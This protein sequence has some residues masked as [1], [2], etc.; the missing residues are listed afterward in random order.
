MQYRYVKEEKKCEDWDWGSVEVEGERR[1]IEAVILLLR[2]RMTKVREEIREVGREVGKSI[3]PSATL[4]SVYD[5]K[6]ERRRGE[7][8]V[9]YGYQEVDAGRR[10]GRCGKIQRKK[11]SGVSE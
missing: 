4:E 9:A 11:G 5:G 6:E 8:E 7:K 3:L 2:F 1:K 10:E